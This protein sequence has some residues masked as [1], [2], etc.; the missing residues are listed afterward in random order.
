MLKKIYQELVTIRKELQ[1]IKNILKPN[2]VDV[3][4]GEKN[5]VISLKM[6]Q[7][8][9]MKEEKQMVVKDIEKFK[10]LCRPVIDYIAENGDPYTEVH[11]SMDSIN[12]TSVECGIPLMDDGD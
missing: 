5:L 6:F 9:R 1:D 7:T 10:A 3:F 8:I 12:V 2:S 11:I 4:I